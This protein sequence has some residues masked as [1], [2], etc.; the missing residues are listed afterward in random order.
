MSAHTEHATD[1]N[2]EALTYKVVL[3]ILLFLTAVT[4]GASYI[5][6]G[7]PSANV[8]IAL[9][10]ATIKAS[11]VSLFFMHL[12]HDKPVNGII[13]MAGFLFLAI[14]LGFV[15][16]DVNARQDPQP[17]VIH[18]P[19]AAPAAGTAAAPDAAPAATPAPAAD[20]RE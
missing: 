6:F 19:A 18:A 4:V 16:M 10:I 13:A 8:V 12:I 15:F 20:K 2:K 1:Y 7:S 11:V 14:F 17:R 3:G 9:T 5:N